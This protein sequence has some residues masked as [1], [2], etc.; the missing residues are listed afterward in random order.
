M[1]AES[2]LFDFMVANLLTFIIDFS[3]DFNPLDFFPLSEILILLKDILFS[4]GLLI[5]SACTAFD[6]EPL[7]IILIFF[8]DVKF[9][10]L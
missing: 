9:P 6:S 1:A 3:F 8:V 5:L 7:V 10:P 4:S 2:S